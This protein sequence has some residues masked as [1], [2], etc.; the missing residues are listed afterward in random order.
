MALI[1]PN[2]DLRLLSV[3]LMAGDGQQMD[4]ATA[5]AQ[6]AYFQ[7][8]T[9][10]TYADFTYQRKDQ[11][12]RVPEDAEHLYNCNY[13]MY[14]NTGHGN[15]WFYAFIT[16][17]EFINQNCA[18]VYIETD[19]FQTWLFD[20]SFRQCLVT[21]ET[22]ADDTIFTH[23]LPENLAAGQTIAKTKTAAMPSGYSLRCDTRAHFDSNYY[24][25]IVITEKI[26]DLYETVQ[27]QKIGFTGGRP[28]SAYYYAGNI[29]E[30]NLALFI[31]NDSGLASAVV[32]VFAAPKYFVQFISLAST[33]PEYQSLGY[34]ANND[35]YQFRTLVLSRNRSGID[36]YTPK[37]NKLYCYPY[38]FVEITNGQ[39][40]A[41]IRY[42][43][44]DS[45]VSDTMDF[46]LTFCLNESPCIGMYPKNY[47][48]E[49]RCV[50]ETLTANDFPL[51]P[52]NYD[53]YRNYLA[54]HSAQ[55]GLSMIDMAA[56]GIVGAATGQVQAFSGAI[57]RAVDTAARFMDMSR[58][59]KQLRNVTGGDFVN[60][61]GETGLFFIQK[62]IKAEY[63]RMIDDYFSRF[64][65]RV[66]IIK[67]PSFKNRPAW[68][69]LQTEQCV[70][71]GD[72]PES[73]SV[74][75]QNLFNAGL[76]VWHDPAH[77]GD[78][79]RNNAPA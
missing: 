16:R 27:P 36:G 13:V 29:Q 71:V 79:S 51:V 9:V 64:G 43:D 49:L 10:K 61:T 52:W 77:F 35:S 66:D 60:M 67:T 62:T 65:Y 45:R 22:V 70:I 73:D 54:L 38:N 3:P 69:F 56:T 46:D 53:S 17:I 32:A 20:F 28:E 74:K 8:K 57:G 26:P 14:R 12:I 19:V 41:E 11:Y 2:T 75:L 31:I 33:N 30:M 15:K 24:M 59:P 47:R 76:T 37:N 23:T 78:Y 44:F 7:G 39:Q 4:F 40:T 5:A 21:R 18:H 50:R 1:S 63:A 42:E 25:V 6:A 72:I 34:L 48:G 58:Q 55:I 68:D